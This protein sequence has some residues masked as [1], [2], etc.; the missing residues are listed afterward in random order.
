M[1]QTLFYRYVGNSEAKDIENRRVISSRTGVTWFTPNRYD[2]ATQA[3]Q[4]LALPLVPTHRVGPIPSDELPDLDVTSLQP[5]APA[6]GYPGGAVEGA[7]SS[8]T[9]IYGIIDLASGTRMSL[10]GSAG[11]SA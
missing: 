9:H 5:V 1:A 11:G 8:V 4:E 6:F 7:T 2:S 3:Q 10:P